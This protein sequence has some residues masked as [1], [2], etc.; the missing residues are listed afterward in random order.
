MIGE[1]GPVA[2][3]AVAPWRESRCSRNAES[4]ARAERSRGC[5]LRHLGRCL[6]LWNNSMLVKPSVTVEAD[7]AV[8]VI[9]GDDCCCAFTHDVN[10]GDF[11][12]SKSAAVGELLGIFSQYPSL[13]RRIGRAVRP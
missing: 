4:S 1:S 8:L 2:A 9:V 13:R 3:P 7:L 12:G 11:E 6:F 10:V 5:W